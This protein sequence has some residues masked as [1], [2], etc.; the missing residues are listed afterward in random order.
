MRLNNLS[1]PNMIDSEIIHWNK[2]KLVDMG[3][4]NNQKSESGYDPEFNTELLEYNYKVL[5]IVPGIHY[6]D[7]N[8]VRQV[9][10]SSGSELPKGRST[11]MRILFCGPSARKQRIWSPEDGWWIF[12]SRL[13]DTWFVFKLQNG[14]QNSN[15]YSLKPDLETSVFESHMN[16]LQVL[17]YEP[18]QQFTAQR[19]QSPYRRMG[20]QRCP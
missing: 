13:F 12:P 1:V 20:H 2:P 16:K 7:I 15:F 4:A 17:K 19:L 10:A 3:V 11:G 6:Y 5:H 18:G 14:L 8:F 9:F